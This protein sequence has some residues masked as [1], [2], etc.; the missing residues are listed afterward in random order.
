[1][2]RLTPIEARE[3]DFPAHDPARRAEAISAMGYRLAAAGP[4]T[5]QRLLERDAG[6]ADTGEPQAAWLPPGLAGGETPSAW[7]SEDEEIEPGLAR[8]STE[9]KGS[10]VWRAAAVLASAACGFA[11][12]LYGQTFHVSRPQK[13]LAS[14]ASKPASPVPAQPAPSTPQAATAQ[15]PVAAAAQQSPAQ[16]S[17]QP[18]MQA[19]AAAPVPDAVAPPAPAAAAPAIP[20]PT[21]RASSPALGAAP[22]SVADSAP[23]A[24]QAA[25]PVPPRAFAA[26]RPAPPRAP[27]HPVFAMAT[28]P[29]APKPLQP[30]PHSPVR[31]AVAQYELPRWLTEDRAQHTQPHV[32]I[33]SP[34][35]HDLEPPP[36]AEPPKQ[37]AAAPAPRPVQRPALIYAEAHTAPQRPPNY[38]AAP[39][40][41]PPGYGYYGNPYRQ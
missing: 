39:Y 14:V 1:M 19:A 36:G 7:D 5:R 24:R 17:P 25:Q 26:W 38:Y 28:R 20:S 27:A 30:R 31:T 6:A 32:L 4:R 41:Y 11:L 16:V 8:L 29:P 2:R 35:P 40:Y 9:H 18:S 37:I 13:L 33:M 22:G 15:P 34:P 23:P 12:V 10:R 3:F 21:Q